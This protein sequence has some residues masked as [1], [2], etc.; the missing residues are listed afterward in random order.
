M[1]NYFRVTKNNAVEFI[2]KKLEVFL[3]KRFDQ[4]GTDITDCVECIGIF[5]MVIDDTIKKGYFLPAMIIM[6]PSEVGSANIDKVAYHKFTF[7]KGDKFMRTNDTIMNHELAFICFLEFIFLGNRPSFMDYNFSA[8]MFETIQDVCGINFGVDRTIFEIIISHL[9][10]QPD[11]LT[12]Y[13]R[14]SNMKGDSVAIPLRA[15]S[16]AAMS[17]SSKMVGS[18][19]NDSINSALVNHSEEVS[20]IENLLRQ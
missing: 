19:F 5:H 14:S 15:V 20:P 2:G 13:F 11:N 10:R 12:A 16:Q 7:V 4:Y 1:K 18:Y 3:P 8:L 6:E 17:T 9:Q